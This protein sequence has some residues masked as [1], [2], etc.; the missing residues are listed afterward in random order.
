[1]LVADRQAECARLSWSSV[2]CPSRARARCASRSRPAASA[3]A[4]RSSRPAPFPASTIPTVPGHEIAGRIDTIGPDVTTWKVGQR[5]GVG[6]FGG[7]CFVCDRC[8]RGDFIT[9]RDLKVPGIHYRR[10]LCRLHD[11]ADRGAGLDS[12]RARRGRGGDR[13][14]APASPP[15]MRC[16]MRR[17]ARRS[18]RHSRHWRARPSRRAIRR[19]AWASTPSPSLAARTRRSSRSSSARIAISTARRKMPRRNLMALGGAKVILTTVTSAQG[20]DAADRRARH[21]RHA[22]RGRRLARADR[23]Q[24]VPVHRRSAAAC[25]AGR[26]APRSIRRTRCASAR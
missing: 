1:M 15:S 10:R 12:R 8:R 21:R 5:V 17:Q 23:G 13:C 2:R 22:A 20:H 19:A 25:E 18:R 16:A 3:T 9:C 6:W 7:A 4:I 26:R 14:S 24:P 11:R